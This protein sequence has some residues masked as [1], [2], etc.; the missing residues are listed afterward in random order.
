MSAKQP[1]ITCQELVAARHDTPLTKPIS[2][3]LAAGDFIQLRGPNGGGKSTMLRQLAGLLP[4]TFGTI[5]VDGIACDAPSIPQRCSISYL[6]HHDGMHGDL[7]GYENFECL[8]G[9]SRLTLPQ[10]S[11]YQRAVSSYSAGQRQKLVITMLDDDH[12]LW[13][14]DE[15]A[16]SLDEANLKELEERMAGFLALGGAIIASTHTPLAQSLVSQMITLSPYHDDRPGI[17]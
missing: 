9:K 2:F 6:G 15:P 8:T 5:L 13:L 16:S 4:T 7:T 11:I 14:L 1:I 17:L 12:D 3:A 10:A